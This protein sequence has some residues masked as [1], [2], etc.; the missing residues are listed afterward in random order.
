MPFMPLQIYRNGQNG[1]NKKSSG[2]KREKKE[3]QKRT[4]LKEKKNIL[5]GTDN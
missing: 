3:S 5:Y 2:I 1:Q 4:R